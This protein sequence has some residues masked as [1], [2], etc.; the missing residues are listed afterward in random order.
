MI[1]FLL[2]SH[3]LCKLHELNLFTRYISHFRFFQSH[4]KSKPAFNHS[5]DW[6]VMLLKE[7]NRL[8]AIKAGGVRDDLTKALAKSPGSQHCEDNHVLSF[9]VIYV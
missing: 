9:I 2:Q 3:R 6:R 4:T 1:L 7:G 8:F 5:E